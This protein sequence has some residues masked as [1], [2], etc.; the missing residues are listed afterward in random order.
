[1]RLLK[2]DEK[3]YP[4]LH[5]YL[6]KD[7]P[8]LIHHPRIS[9]ALLKYGQIKK[10]TLPMIL[11]YGVGPLVSVIT[12]VNACGEFTPN[13]KSNEVRIHKSLVDRFE[14]HSKDKILIMT[15]GATLLH[16][17]AHWGDDQ[18][19]VDYPGEEGELFERSVYKLGQHHCT[20]Y[21]SDLIKKGVI[22]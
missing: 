17:L 7:F 14:K 3:N 21:Y 2:H 16:E 19:G 9:N 11:N 6:K 18:D 4:K 22:F 1:M 12:L 13:A 8:K 15:V 20:Y 5:Y 10:A